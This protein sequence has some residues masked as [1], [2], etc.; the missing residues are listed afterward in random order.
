MYLT[1]PI[2]KEFE[3]NMRVHNRYKILQICVSEE[4]L[5]SSSS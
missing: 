4:E 5:K 2:I 3:M 1:D